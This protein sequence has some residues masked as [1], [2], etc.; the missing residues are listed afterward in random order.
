MRY[1][2]FSL[3]HEIDREVSLEIS[4]MRLHVSDG[5]SFQAGSYFSD[6]NSSPGGSRIA[7]PRKGAALIS[8]VLAFITALLC[9]LVA[10]AARDN[11]LGK[12]L[13]L[14]FGHRRVKQAL[15]LR[16]QCTMLP[17]RRTKHT[18]TADFRGLCITP[19]TP[20]SMA[21][22]TSI[23]SMP[24]ATGTPTPTP[25][26]NCFQAAVGIST[27]VNKSVLIAG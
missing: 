9:A 26:T 20:M 23:I 11:A 16:I 7:C 8:D 10:A 1:F 3:A 25:T 6:S 13:T 27:W 2:A 5:I 24:R 19:I 4:L 22:R 21:T 12:H 14:R 15:H 18:A 17:M